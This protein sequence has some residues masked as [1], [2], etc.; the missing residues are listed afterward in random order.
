MPFSAR[1]LFARLIKCEAGGEGIDGMKAVATVVMNRVHASYGEYLRTGQGDLRKVIFQ[2]TQF[3][4]VMSKVYGEVNPQT[5]WSSPPE[6]IHYDIAD[7]ALAGNKLP[8]VG[9]CLW[10]YNPFSATCNYIFPASGSGQ[11]VT[12]VNQHCF[13]RPT[14]FYAQT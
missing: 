13:Y 1:E 8:G 12:R 7:W 5:I 3:T 14:E 4:C 6:Q 10:Y 11:F 9:E 2:P